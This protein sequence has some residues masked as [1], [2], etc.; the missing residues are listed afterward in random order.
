MLAGSV[1]E[2]DKNLSPNPAFFLVGVPGS[3]TTLLQEALNAHPSLA[4]AADLHELTKYYET[5]TGLQREGLIAPELVLKWVEQKR[6]DPFEVDRAEIQ[7]LIP[8]GKLLPY[9]SFI[10][11]LLDGFGHLK[12]K[13]LVGSKTLDYLRLLPSVHALWPNAKVVHLIRDGRNVCLTALKGEQRNISVRQYSSWVE[14]PIAT[15]ALWW[16]WNIR[17]GQQAGQGLG[18]ELYLE[19]S[20]EAFRDRPAE[21]CAR[22]LT[23]LGVPFEDAVLRLMASQMQAAHADALRVHA[24]WRSQMPAAD[25]ER[26]EAAAGDL[27]NELGYTRAHLCPSADALQQA[28]VIRGRLV[29]EMERRGP[30]PEA[31]AERRRVNGR[32]NPFVFIVG[33]PRSG[34]TLLQ[35]ILDAHPDLAVCPETFWIPY[36]FKRKIGLTSEGLVTPELIGKLFEY[37][38]FYRM[39]ACREELEELTAGNESLGYAT[40]VTRIFDLYGEIRGKPLVGDKTPDYVRNLRTLHDLWPTAKFIHL[41]RDGRDVALS[42]MNWRRKVAKLASLFRTWREEPVITAAVWWEWHVRHGREAGQVLGPERYYEMRYE[43]LVADAA[44]EIRQLCDFLRLQFDETMLHFHEGRTQ[45]EAGLDA[46]NSWRPITSGLR[47]WRSQMPP[48]DQECFELA[49][50]DL[51][52]ELDYPCA[53]PRPRPDA[54]PRVARVRAAF[55]RD[56]ESLGDWL[57]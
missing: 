1:P 36:Y 18:P 44:T 9:Q 47:D 55:A 28:Q 34:T 51:L 6:F 57:P 42:A 54:L 29:P 43:A 22:L 10:S 15:A 27:L 13:R 25:V 14:A 45:A 38:K 35:R 39:K 52:N 21:E 30:S 49:V 11:R 7:R 16:E 48:A 56:A 41:I 20:S 37:Y 23:F 40:F 33:C 8:A 3:G 46:K 24:D 32:T 4:V 12:G 31:L 5:R 2:T 19:I 53:F 50:A 17:Q 26:F